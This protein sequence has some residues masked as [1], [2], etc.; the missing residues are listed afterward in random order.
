MT[1]QDD[2]PDRLENSSQAAKIK[3]GT[4]KVSLLDNAESRPSQQME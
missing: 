2:V 4:V 1:L 3:D